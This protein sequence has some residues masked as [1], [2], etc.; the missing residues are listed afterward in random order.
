MRRARGGKMRRRQRRDDFVAPEIPFDLMIHILGRLPAKSLMRFRCVSKLWSG[1]IRSR[2]FTNLYLTVASSRLLPRPLGLYMSLVENNSND[3]L[4]LWEYPRKHQL[5]SLRLSSSI[6][7]SESS[8]KPELTFPG[9]GGHKMVVL[10]GLIL[11]SLCRKA[12]IYNP[13]TRQDVILPAIKSKI[14]DQREPKYVHYF[15]GHDP[16]HDHYKIVCTIVI[17]PRDRGKI[18]SE[19]WVFLLEPGG[20]WKKVEYDDQPHMP[21]REGFCINGVIYYLAFTHTCR[22]NVYCFDVRSEEFS[23]IQ[24]P[25]EVSEFGQSVGFIEHGGKPA[26]LDYTHIGETGVSE[27]WVLEVDGGTWLRKSLVLKPCQRHLVDDI[28]ILDLSVHGTGQNDEVI[29]ALCW[30]CYLLC[31]DLIKNDLRKVIINREIT[32]DQHLFVY[33]KVMD[34]CE[35]IMHL[36]L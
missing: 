29:L 35:N 24:A 28:D 22:D 18:T 31:Y 5:L 26:L 32:P 4:E 17:H 36:E 6:N 34:K 10:R 12:C 19:H 13:T 8:L 23:K 14:L 25:L 11:Y 2:Y 9:M 7:S 3:Y 33:V 16:V 30:P 15:F 1:L 21:T 27:L 20:F